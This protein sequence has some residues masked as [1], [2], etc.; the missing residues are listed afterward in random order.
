MKYPF[1]RNIRPLVT[2][3][4]KSV[5]VINPD[6]KKVYFTYKNISDRLRTC[7]YYSFLQL[8]PL[9]LE[10]LLLY[11]KGFVWNSVPSSLKNAQVWMVLNKQLK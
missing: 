8:F 5:T 7:L 2:E 9:T 3:C 11:L 1:I 4:F 6:C 10:Q